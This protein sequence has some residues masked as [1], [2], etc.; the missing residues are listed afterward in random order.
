[1]PGFSTSGTFKIFIGKIPEKTVAQDIKPLFERYGKVVECDV[2][3]N[4][5]FVHMEDP[6]AGY[7]AIKNLNGAVVNGSS[8]TVEEAK[9]K[10]RP[11]L[12]TTK[13]FVG[14]IPDAVKA[15]DLRALFSRYGTVAECDLVRNY[16]FVHIDTT[17]LTKLLKEL[18][19]Y[20]IGGQLLK[21]QIS[22]SKVRQK[23]G[24][25]NPQ[26][27]YNTVPNQ[28]Q[29]L[30]ETMHAVPPRTAYPRELYPPPPPSAAFIRERILSTYTVPD[31]RDYYDHY[32]QTTVER[33]DEYAAMAAARRE[34]Y[35]ATSRVPP[36]SE[37]DVFSR[38]SPN[39]A[40]AVAT[41][42]TTDSRAYDEYSGAVSYTYPEES[43]HG[44]GDYATSAVTSAAAVDPYAVDG[45]AAAAAAAAAVYED[46]ATA[47]TR[48]AHI[49]DRRSERRDGTSRSS[50]RYAPY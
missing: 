36:G 15:S 32:C 3:K 9:S 35:S 14:N 23:P 34:P 12:P 50:S 2:V 39:S 13:I 37:Y 41:H 4:Y 11:T 10:K 43:W 21:V 33:Y 47:M 24:M 16:G 19:G 8:I 22:T 26:Q 6:M 38:R 1:M 18:N 31:P 30:P 17:D 29:Y 25:G 46:Y 40:A 27:C 49:D 5:G 7:E 28:P 20:E 45:R 44:Y 48:S 42:Y